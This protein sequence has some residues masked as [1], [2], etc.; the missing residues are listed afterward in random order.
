MSTALPLTLRLQA[1]LEGAPAGWDRSVIITQDRDL[2]ATTATLMD[3]LYDYDGETITPRR[4]QTKH[5]LH[6]S[7]LEASPAPDDL[8]GLTLEAMA[9]DLDQEHE[10]AGS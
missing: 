4:L 9:R 3:V 6:R 7:E 5:L 10:G 2:E 8:I 1:I